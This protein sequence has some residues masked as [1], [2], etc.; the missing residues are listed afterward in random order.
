[1]LCLSEEHEVGRSIQNS[2]VM[3]WLVKGRVEQQSEDDYCSLK[4][5]AFM[6][7]LVVAYHQFHW[8]KAPEL[9]LC[10]LGAVLLACVQGIAVNVDP[11]FYVWLLQLPQKMNVK[12]RSQ[13]SVGVIQSVMPTT[14]KKE[15][16]VSV[17]S[18][19]LAMQQSNQASEYASSPVKTKTATESRPFS[20]PIKVMQSSEEWSSPE[21]RMKEF[22][23]LV[24]DGVK[25]LTLQLEVQSCCVFFPNESLPSPSTIVAGDIP[26][27]VRNWY[28]TE[29]NMPGTLVICLPQIKVIS[30]GHK[31][32]EPLQE[33]PFVISR[34]ILDEGDAFPWTIS[35]SQFSV[36]TLLGQLKACN[37]LEPLGCT[38]TLAITSHKLQSSSPET[39]HSFVVCLHVDLES[40][41][42]KCSNPQV[43]VGTA[44]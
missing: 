35:L 13:Q 22:I 41:E 5:Q 9:S 42:M 31:Y 3:L 44:N 4:F 1:M 26:G 24:W 43:G 15:D 12:H 30:A 16:E 38:S 23:G 40:L 33:I 39:R 32:M 18:T 10:V 28:H 37:L 36:Y 19:P 27:T 34:P 11:I 29:V 21:E 2:R 20:V 6:H 14:R 8:N 17:G 7:F 25:R